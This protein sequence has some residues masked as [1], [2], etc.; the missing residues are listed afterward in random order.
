MPR[1]KQ[2]TRTMLSGNTAVV[3]S[4]AGFEQTESVAVLDAHYGDVATAALADVEKDKQMWRALVFEVVG[5]KT[6]P[7]DFVL[8]RLAPSVGLSALMAETKFQE[9]VTAILKLHNAQATKIKYEEKK[10]A[11]VQEHATEAELQ[12]Q[13]AA[14]L[15][16]TKDLRS[17]INEVQNYDRVIGKY[18]GT[19]RRIGAAFTRLF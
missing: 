17:L 6:S 10:A 2:D 1:K 5:G 11:F 14:M 12:T 15:Q 13:L 3:E 4:V 8:K 19:T 18:T 9:D 16:E 7:P